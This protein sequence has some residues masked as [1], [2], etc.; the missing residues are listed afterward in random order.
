ML[1]SKIEINSTYP[2]GVFQ[3]LINASIESE[4]VV[5]DLD[6]NGCMGVD[7]AP[8]GTPSKP[9]ILFGVFSL[10]TLLRLAESTDSGVPG[11][12]EGFPK[13]F[14]QLRW[15]FNDS[16]TF[17]FR[18]G[19]SGGFVLSFN[20]FP[21]AACLVGLWTPR[22]GLKNPTWFPLKPRMTSPLSWLE[23]LNKSI[24]YNHF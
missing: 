17:T 21:L 20:P 1:D 2:E 13:F 11:V 7:L 4:V 24:F 18:L 10:F 19:L 16:W 15:F 8:L 14:V 12:P 6:G 5:R 9:D 23:V 3:L 22:I